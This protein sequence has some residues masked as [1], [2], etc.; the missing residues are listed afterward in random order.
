M[1]KVSSDR[2]YIFTEPINNDSLKKLSEWYRKQHDM[3]PEG[4]V[5]I[6]ITCAG[7]STAVGLAAIDLMTVIRKGRIQ[8]I[9]LGDVS[10]MAIP[11]FMAGD[12]RVVTPRT[13]FLIHEGGFTFSKDT[14]W[15][16][17][18]VEN[19]LDELKVDRSFYTE[20]VASRSS[21]KLTPERIIGMMQANTHLRGAEA[22]E[23]GIA[24]ELIGD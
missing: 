14:R 4:W 17:S 12:Y 5:S 2:T 7:G 20:Y 21:G 24:H 9:G 15:T 10:S 19:A 8:T 22:V 23:L 16:I 3:E 6:E 18:E 11:L 13:H 1:Q